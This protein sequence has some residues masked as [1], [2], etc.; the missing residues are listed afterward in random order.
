MCHS[1]ACMRKK[2][3]Q[4]Q[5]VQKFLKVFKII[6]WVPESFPPFLLYY[7]HY[8]LSPLQSI[9]IKWILFQSCWG[10]CFSAQCCLPHFANVGDRA[11]LRGCSLWPRR[12]PSTLLAPAVPGPL[13]CLPRRQA[14]APL[15]GPHSSLRRIWSELQIKSFAASCQ[16]CPGG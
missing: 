2:H 13:R 9:F 15:E 10:S 6:F 4:I 14:R 12:L 7:F 11:F 16:P 3:K 5:L 1:C 8:H